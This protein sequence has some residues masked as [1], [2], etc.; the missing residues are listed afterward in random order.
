MMDRHLMQL[1][2]ELGGRRGCM[3]E[4]IEH[5]GLQAKFSLH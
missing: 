1:W 3:L 4:Y 5:A 2:V